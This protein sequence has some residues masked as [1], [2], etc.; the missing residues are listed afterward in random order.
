MS[1]HALAHPKSGT[2][3]PIQGDNQVLWETLSASL[4]ALDEQH[5]AKLERLRH[6]RMPMIWQK[7]IEETLCRG[8]T[9]K[10]NASASAATDK[11]A[12]VDTLCRTW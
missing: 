10:R 8:F 3:L 1:L 6:S 2:S 11:A 9:A 7:E 4:L 12:T 5:A